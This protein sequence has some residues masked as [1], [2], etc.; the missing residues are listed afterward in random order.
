[1]FSNDFGRLFALEGS[2]FFFRI[3]NTAELF[4]WSLGTV[5]GILVPNCFNLLDPGVYIFSFAPTP[6][7]IFV[8][9][10]KQVK[11]RGK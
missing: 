10:E 3:R 6:A 7:N 2:S 1:M 9:L 4:T 11:I 5:L 8:Y